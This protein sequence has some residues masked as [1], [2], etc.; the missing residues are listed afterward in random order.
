M[1]DC[2]PSSL[3]SLM[4]KVDLPALLPPIMAIRSSKSAMSNFMNAALSSLLATQLAAHALASQGIAVA[5]SGGGDSWALALL[6]YDFC[7]SNNLPFIA[8]TV[9][10]QLRPG[11]ADEA[12]MVAAEC[13]RR[14]MPHAALTWQHGGITSRRQ[15]QARNARYDLLGTYCE[16]HGF[17]H[18]LTA[19]HADDQAETVLLRF[20]RGS[21]AKGLSGMSASRP[22]TNSVT[23]I[24]PFLAIPKA[25]LMAYATAAGVPIAADPSNENSNYARPRLRAARAVLEAEG[26]TTETLLKTAAVARAEDVA[27]DYAA[28]KLILDYAVFSPYGGVRLPYAPFTAATPMLRRYAWLKIWRHVTRD[29]SYPP[30]PA[31][32]DASCYKL[33]GSRPVRRT[34][35]GMVQTANKQDLR[36]EREHSAIIPLNVF[37]HT[38]TVFDNRYKIINESDQMVA[39]I[40][41]SGCHT[42][43][44]RELAPWALSVPEDCNALP[45]AL[46]AG[47]PE[48][49]NAG[50]PILPLRLVPYGSK[51]ADGAK[52]FAHLLSEP[53]PSAKGSIVS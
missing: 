36:F 24:R 21:G 40:P 34:L 25:D 31:A 4:D 46:W 38:Q 47:T 50:G 22:L 18:L 45:A 16:T 10:H 8:L 9:D 3:P 5:L 52:V 48:D 39:I 30:T 12:T 42:K 19:H 32:I 41:T 1:I 37:P 15:E 2:S 13:A 20:A 17:A 7:K 35:G 43:T 53:N 28:Q 14:G 23:L 6:S 11:S 29:Q 44:K 33:A 26:L 49:P 27:L 51:P